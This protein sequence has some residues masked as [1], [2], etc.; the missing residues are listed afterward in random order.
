M[1]QSLAGFYPR[2]IPTLY[3]R[4]IVLNKRWE[5]EGRKSGIQR[6]SANIQESLY[7]LRL[8]RYCKVMASLIEALSKLELL[9][10]HIDSGVSTK[11]PNLQKPRV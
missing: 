10:E 2:N 7:V 4:R 5:V 3:H 8:V 1:S 11:W 9:V 6:H